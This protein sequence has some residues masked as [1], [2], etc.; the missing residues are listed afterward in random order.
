MYS[1]QIHLTQTDES[2]TDTIIQ[3]QSEP[4]SNSNEKVTPR[5]SKH[6]N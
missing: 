6:Q 5:S 2:Q 4:G 1:Q 3:G